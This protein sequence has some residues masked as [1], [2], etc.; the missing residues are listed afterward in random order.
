MGLCAVIETLPPACTASPETFPPTNP[1]TT[2]APALL[3]M[4][5]PDVAIPSR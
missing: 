2:A 5:E 4:N 3:T 1:P